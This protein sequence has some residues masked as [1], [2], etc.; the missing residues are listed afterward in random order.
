MSLMMV[1]APADRWAH[2]TEEIEGEGRRRHGVVENE[3]KER[4]A[5]GVKKK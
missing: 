3:E 2:T 1:I 4:E 5:W